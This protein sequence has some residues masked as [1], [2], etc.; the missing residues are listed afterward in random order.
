[1]PI[2]PS[3]AGR[4]HDLLR[5]LASQRPA[6]RDSAVA[7]LTLLGPRVIEP[8]LA[9]LPGSPVPARK[10]ALEVLERLDDPRAR[11]ALPTLAEDASQGVALRAIEAIAEGG[12]TRSVPTLARVLGGGTPRRREAAARALARLHGAGV[13]E[14]LAPLVDTIVDEQAAAEL[15]VLILDE[16][17]RLQPPLPRSTLRLLG[18]RLTTSRVPALAARGTQLVRGPGPGRSQKREG[19]DPL[20]RLASGRVPPAEIDAIVETL[21]RDTHLPLDRLHEGLESAR[22]PGVIRALARVLADV[23]GAA[24]IP[25]LSRALDR[26]GAAVASE[27]VDE[28][29]VAGRAAIHV[30]LARLDSRV[31]LH[32][33]RELIMLRPPRVMPQALEAAASVGDGSLVPA[34]ARAATE[35]PSLLAACARTYTAIARRHGI[36]RTS[37]VLRKV[38]PEHREVLEAFLASQS[39]RR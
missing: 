21:R 29:R 32:D 22:D 39:R 11:A 17:V 37:A 26:V 14:A 25:V 27:D 4:V 9:S 16:I 8:L 20:G 3:R 1:M 15:R 38:R 13:V 28:S 10:A 19:A 31:A 18:R 30:A 24:S 5:H 2:V 35:D 12:D 6:E 34:L 23:G 33:L 7:Q 36:R